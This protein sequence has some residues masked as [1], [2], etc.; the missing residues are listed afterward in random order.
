M[1]RLPMSLNRLSFGSDWGADD[2]SPFPHYEGLNRLSFGS[3][4]GDV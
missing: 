2:Y 4:W 3:D 1:D